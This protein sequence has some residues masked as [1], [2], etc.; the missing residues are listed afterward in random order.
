MKDERD[1]R[2]VTDD[3]GNE[4]LTDENGNILKDEAG[5]NIPP[6]VSR[7]VLRSSGWAFHDTSQ[8][9]CALCGRISCR[10]ECFK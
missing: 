6:S 10:G 4:W 7:K 5:N 9:H 2:I 3:F 1:N 8:G